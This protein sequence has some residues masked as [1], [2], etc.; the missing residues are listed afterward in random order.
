MMR[1]VI[2]NQ[3]Y[4]SWSLRG[5][6]AVK[7]SGLPFETICLPLRTDEF[8][9][10]IFE[11]SPSGKVP[12][13]I[14]GDT[15]IWDSL[16]ILDYLDRKCADVAYWPEALPAYGL[17]RAMTAEFHSGFQ[18][19]R[20]A[21]AYNLSMVVDGFEVSDAVAADVARIEDLWTECRTRFG[22]D[23]PYLFGTW[24][25]ADMV[26]APVAGR[27]DTYGLGT[28]DLV[29]AY[30]EAVR[31]HPHMTEWIEGAKAEAPSA[32]YGDVPKGRLVP[33]F[34]G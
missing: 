2:G 30:C 34:Q 29:R 28:T 3:T 27:F 15:H 18:A 21:C 19:L 6:L 22:A 13:L 16:A 5:W 31:S 14:D 25:A 17:A 24:S 26:Y 1:L 4:S 9:T 10:R 20:S 33:G 7:A 11:F 23:G 8:A 32:E 12:C